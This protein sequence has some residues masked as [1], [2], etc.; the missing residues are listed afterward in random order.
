MIK[1]LLQ[2]SFFYCSLFIHVVQAQGLTISEVVMDPT[3]GN[4][5]CEFVELKNQSNATIDIGSWKITDGESGINEWTATFPAGTTLNAWEYVVVAKNTAAFDTEYGGGACAIFEITNVGSGAGLAN[6]GDNVNLLNASGTLVQTYLWSSNTVDRAVF[7]G[8]AWI[9]SA[10]GTDGDPCTSLILPIELTEFKARYDQSVFLSWRTA[11]ETAN[12]FF[13]VERSADSRTFTETGRV[14]GAGATA[15]PRNYTFTDE[16]PLP[17]LSYYR[18]RQVDFDGQFAYSPVVAIQTGQAAGIRVFPSPATDVLNIQ[19]E[20]APEEGAV[21]EVFDRTGRLVQ[22]SLFPAETT[23]S[24]LN[25]AG[26]PTGLYQLRII[27]GREVRVQQ[28]LVKR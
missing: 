14:K 19:L 22:T 17:G 8:S 27:A 28:F 25:T 5:D 23:G 16:S 15:E 6:P 18:L 4:D 7:D 21:L 9:T 24:E 2:I 20:T 12:D 1:L 10:G 13:A 26:L 11:T 3:C